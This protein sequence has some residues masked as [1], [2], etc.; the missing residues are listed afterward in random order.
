MPKRAKNLAAER[1]TAAALDAGAVRELK[2]PRLVLQRQ[3]SSAR[4]S[5]PVELFFKSRGEHHLLSNFYGGV[6]FLYQVH[7]SASVPS[8]A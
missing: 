2:R 8:C 6:E 5:L 4:C 1:E 7:S 3:R